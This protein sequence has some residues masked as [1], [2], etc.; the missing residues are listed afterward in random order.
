MT[1]S[2]HATLHSLSIF[3]Q[4]GWIPPDCQLLHDL[5]WVDSLTEHL[6]FPLYGRSCTCPCCK[7]CDVIWTAA[8][9]FKKRL[10]SPPANEWPILYFLSFDLKYTQEVLLILTLA[11][12][13]LWAII[14][15]ESA[16]FALVFLV[17]T[18]DVTKL[19]DV[20][21]A[22]SAVAASSCRGSTSLAPAQ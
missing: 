22:S 17:C 7:G 6:L 5:R 15:G 18:V 4:Y 8:C 9:F 14:K 13:L 3:W 10:M 12:F 16:G 20:V 11:V 2:D 19:P 21:F 1:E